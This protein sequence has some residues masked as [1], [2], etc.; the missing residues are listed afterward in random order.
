MIHDIDLAIQFNGDIKSIEAT[1]LID[2]INIE[3]A[4]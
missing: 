4:K 1:G 2:K 3:L